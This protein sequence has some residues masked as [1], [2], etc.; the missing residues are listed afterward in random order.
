[1][2]I[3]SIEYLSN[4]LLYK[5]FDYLD[6]WDIYAAFSHL[7]YHFEQLINNSSFLYKIKR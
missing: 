6:A 7:N 3:T 1:M 2:S 4:E 5:I